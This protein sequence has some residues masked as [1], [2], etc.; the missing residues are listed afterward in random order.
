MKR[1]IRERKLTPEEAV[2]Y[3]AV[4]KQVAEELPDLIG[5]HHKRMA[6]ADP[7]PE[8]LKQER[9]VRQTNT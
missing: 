9:V 4:R 3:T 8:F 5:R 7:M 6:S 2:K 1:I